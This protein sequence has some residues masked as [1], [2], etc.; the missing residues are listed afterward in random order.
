MASRLTHLGKA[1]TT[2]RQ[3]LI[4]GF[5]VLLALGIRLWGLEWKAPHHDEGVNGWF[6]LRLAQRGLVMYDPNNY[7]GPLLYYLTFPSILWFGHTTASLRLPLALL[8]SAS[9]L[10]FLPLKRMAGFIPLT[11]GLLG[12]ALSTG[13][14][15]YARTAIH[16]TLLLFLSIGFVVTTFRWLEKPSIRW[17]QW[18]MALLVGMLLT[19]ETVLIHGAATLLA[20]GF[21]FMAYP[22][23][24][25]TQQP[26]V[27]L[28]S[29]NHHTKQ[30][31][32]L[33]LGLS[34]LILILGYTSFFEWS[35]G[36]SGFVEGFFQWGHRGFDDLGH[37]KP[38]NYYF[39]IWLTQERLIFVGLLLWLARLVALFKTKKVF[40]KRWERLFLF[41]GSYGVVTMAIYT[42]L[43]YK[44]PWLSIQFSWPW[45]FIAGFLVGRMM[46]YKNLKA[47]IRAVIASVWASLIIF[48]LILP[49]LRCN[50]VDY[51][52]PQQPYAYVQTFRPI[53]DVVQRLE[54]QAQQIPELW[55]EPIHV[56]MT[57]YWPLPW[58][59]SG[60]THVHYWGHGPLPQ[61][62]DSWILFVDADQI[63]HINS[64]LKGSYYHHV[65]NLRPGVEGVV[66]LYNRRY[67]HRRHLSSP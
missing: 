64:K 46:V 53:T 32:L 30:Q 2:H 43:P 67:F 36:L 34:G 26:F 33:T 17:F 3:S 12:L 23:R 22:Q 57:Q 50:F 39:K 27:A 16:E 42:A 55:D 65:L 58:L 38:W 35:K 15:Y 60:F 6:T 5:M 4:I 20:M 49:S 48:W 8:G 11:L 9:L 18:I 7:H 56:V 52:N 51:D 44:T 13:L 31:I 14:V 21:W 10:W 59:L 47:P 28:M 61:S 66:V 40:Y 62:L 1:L 25:K 37:L 45:L 19:K 63:E 54:Q 41:L 29:L 24:F